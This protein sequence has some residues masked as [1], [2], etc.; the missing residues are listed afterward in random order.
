HIVMPLLF[1]YKAHATNSGVEATATWNATDRWKLIPNYTFLNMKVR[2]NATSGD[3]RIEQTPGLSP[4]A[5]FGVRSLVDLPHRME[6]DQTI[7]YVGALTSAGVP[8]YT[9]VDTRLGWRIGESAE[10][11]IVGQNLLRPRRAEF[12]DSFGLSHTEVER[13]VSLKLTWRF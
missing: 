4:R 6:W 13:S 11:S 10:F 3:T 5:Q 8:A 9:R 7:G 12:F 2:R 1:E